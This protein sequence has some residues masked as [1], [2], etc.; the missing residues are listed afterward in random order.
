MRK[1]QTVLTFLALAMMAA[2]A[3]AA[4]DKAPAVK[5]FSR[6]FTVNKTYLVIPIHNGAKGCRLTLTVDGK[7]V[8]RYGT[9]L[10]ADAESVDWYAFF[11]I[12]R[13]KGK[14][15]TVS[16]NRATKEGFALIRQSDHIPGE[17]KFYTE[18]LRPQFHFSQKVGWNNDP[19]GMVYYDGEWHLFF[20]HNPVGH[21][22]GNMTWGHAVSKDLVH[23]KQLP[24]ALF[25]S[26][27]AKGA[28]FSGS[29]N[30]DHNNTAG[31][32]T[33]D[34]KVMVAALTDTGAGEAIAYSNDRGRTFTWYEKN[35]V[36]KHKGRDPKIIW[37]EP[38]KHW[39]MAVFDQREGSGGIAFYTSPNLKD[40][41][42]Q[43]R[44]AGYHECPE[45][46]ELPVDGDAKNTR[47]VVYAGDA[48]YV[49]GSFD[50]KTFT[51]AHEGKHRV[52][53]GNYYASQRF[54]NP[55]DGR[56][57]QI[58]WARIGMKGMPFNQTFS[59]PCRLTLHK[60]PD[61]IRMF[62]KPI[63][64]IAL[65]HKKKHA[66]GRTAVKPDAPASVK[67]AGRLFDIRATFDV[68]DKAKTFGVQVGDRKVTYDVAKAKLEG[69]P[70]AP[71]DGKITMQILV[72]RPMIEV[73]GN[74]GRVYQTKPF[75]SKDE[76]ESVRAFAGGGPVDLVSL[77]VYELKS[78]WK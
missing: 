77:E 64:E 78:I 35:P 30:I 15:A 51:P 74:D 1:R 16:V 69:M 42:Y 8:R 48:K 34:E 23:W 57:I 24:N 50:G 76:I 61:G 65:L 17:E 3:C 22:W 4:E 26:T 55:P 9:G 19:N 32:Q 71:V 10:A 75:H 47:W 36:V 44:I 60:T 62:A 52:H 41:T 25:P 70:L 72:D 29:A 45:L 20:Q 40:W 12:E 13:Y 56:I 37:Y 43:S 73:C 68:G 67:T 63:K 5:A 11:T 14:R 49:L 39:V 2:V 31:F 54:S 38:G 33:G 7:P 66:L 46:F 21:G 27:M 18:P 59:F 58:G 53:W 28:C 6:D